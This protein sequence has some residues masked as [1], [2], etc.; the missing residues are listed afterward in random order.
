MGMITPLR[1]EEEENGKVGESFS[2]VCITFNFQKACLRYLNPVWQN[3]H[4]L[5]GGGYVY[6]CRVIFVRLNYFFKQK[7]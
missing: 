2:Y 3:V 1:R 4:I 6:V 7:I 5:S